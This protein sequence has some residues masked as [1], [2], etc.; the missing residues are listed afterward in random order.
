[1]NPLSFKSL[2]N[3]ES[4]KRRKKTSG[5]YVLVSLTVFKIKTNLS[6]TIFTKTQKNEL[7]CLF[8]AMLCSN[9]AHLNTIMS[10]NT[11]KPL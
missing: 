7:T 10:M 9:L 8:I 5:N 3:K 2:C 4:E 1:M 11:I 6:G